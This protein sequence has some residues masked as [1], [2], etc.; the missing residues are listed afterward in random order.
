MAKWIKSN[1]D[2]VFKTKVILKALKEQKTFAQLGSEFELFT[3][4][5]SN[6]KKQALT[7]IPNLFGAKKGVISD[8]QQEE[9]TSQLY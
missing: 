1:Y 7:G 3:P 6:L 4:Q 9:L 2:E 5:I 8:D